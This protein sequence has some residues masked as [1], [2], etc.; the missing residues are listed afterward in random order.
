MA[1]DYTVVVCDEASPT[2]WRDFVAEGS[3]VPRCGNG[4]HQFYYGATGCACRKIKS[5]TP[6]GTNERKI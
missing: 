1:D 6:V 2:R 5:T 4:I 3:Y